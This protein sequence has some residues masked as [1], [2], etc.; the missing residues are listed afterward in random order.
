MWGTRYPANLGIP[1]V[2]AVNQCYLQLLQEADQHFY[3]QQ[4]L[5]EGR[6][7]QTGSV[8]AAPAALGPNAAG[9]SAAEID[10]RPLVEGPTPAAEGVKKEGKSKRKDKKSKK[11]QASSA[12]GEPEKE[13]KRSRREEDRARD[14]EKREVKAEPLEKESN[15]PGLV[16]LKEKP[17][18]SDWQ[19]ESESE[20]EDRSVSK[21]PIVR[22]R[23]PVRPRSPHS[24]PPLR[25]EDTRGTWVGPIP[26]G[27][28]SRPPE[29]PPPAGVTP[30][31][32]ARKPKNKGKRKRERQE[33]RWR[34][35]NQQGGQPQ[36]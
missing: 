9:G 27:R 3:V 2:R 22:R 34:E 25:R 17:A 30:K 15:K 6:G 31:S 1:A 4:S 35:R 24:P 8:A 18:E 36:G 29:D 32:L 10:K 5:R 26:A 11:E 33:R 28:R 13:K 12:R 16:D 23:S 7:A 19:E 21:S 14:Q 20:V